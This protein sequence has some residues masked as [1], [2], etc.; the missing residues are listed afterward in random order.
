MKITVAFLL[1]FFNLEIF[2]Q[3]HSDKLGLL[4]SIGGGFTPITT[5]YSPDLSGKFGLVYESI[6]NVYDLNIGLTLEVG[7]ISASV[8]K[9]DFQLDE[10]TIESKTKQAIIPITFSAILDNDKTL[11]PII[12]IGIGLGT[13][14]FKKEYEEYSIRNVNAQNWF[15]VLI[16]GTGLSYKI[17]SFKFALI[18]DAT[19][20]NGNLLDKNEIGFQDGYKGVQTD[21]FI[22]L[23][24]SYF[25][26]I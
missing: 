8:S 6:A 1:I 13:K 16:S 26:K 10:R 14:T 5:Y 11:S 23:Q 18:L 25:I 24:C 2:S 7:Y 3:N 19:I 20:I 4:F 22:G 9:F 21:V 12:K 17:N 15:F